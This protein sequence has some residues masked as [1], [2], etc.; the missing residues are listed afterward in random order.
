M[1]KS[2]KKSRRGRRSPKKSQKSLQKINKEMP[3]QPL[4]LEPEIHEAEDVEEQPLPDA[5][6]AAKEMLTHFFASLNSDIQ[7]N[8]W[9]LSQLPEQQ[10]IFGPRSRCTTG[11]A[12]RSPS[13][14]MTT[15]RA[16]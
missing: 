8:A 5:V 15:L 16:R 9:S 1:A 13:S 10:F 11:R 3:V 4:Q 7:T 12:A 14:A 2:P 6:P